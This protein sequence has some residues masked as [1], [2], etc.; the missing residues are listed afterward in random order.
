MK[1]TLSNIV[2]TGRHSGFYWLFVFVFACVTN[3]YITNMLSACLLFGITDRNAGAF[4][5]ISN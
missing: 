2:F 5:N 4:A 3:T 1:Y